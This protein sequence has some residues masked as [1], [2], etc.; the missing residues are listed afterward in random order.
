MKH[1]IELNLATVYI[2]IQIWT[3][4]KPLVSDAFLHTFLSAKKYNSVIKCCVYV[5]FNKIF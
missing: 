1:I 2:L 4:R 5:C 3:N